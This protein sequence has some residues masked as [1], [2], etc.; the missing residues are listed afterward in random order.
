M[1]IT[2]AWPFSV[3]T[4]EVSCKSNKSGV[5]VEHGNEILLVE[6]SAVK[7]WIRSDRKSG[8]WNVFS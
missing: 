8:M 2:I 1:A 6:P 4:A 5:T 3:Y 7:R